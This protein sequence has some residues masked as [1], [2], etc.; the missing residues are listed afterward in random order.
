MLTLTIKATNKDHMLWCDKDNKFIQIPNDVTVTMEHSLIS[1]SKW[2]SKWRKAFI[3][4]FSDQG[5]VPATPDEEIDYFRCMIVSPSNFNPEWIYGL[6]SK[7]AYD[8]LHYISNPMSATNVQNSN[9]PK[10]TGKQDVMTSELIYYYM[11]QY[12][13]PVE[14]EKWHFN[15]LMTLIKVCSVKAAEENAKYN[16]KT[17][18]IGKSELLDNYA[19]INAANK[20]KLHSRG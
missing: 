13:I 4:T 14:F 15:R 3:K 1:V 8:I 12:N 2:E 11:I 5:P 10:K 16:K 20:A 9:E 18:R 6:S 7:Q 17:P 19:K